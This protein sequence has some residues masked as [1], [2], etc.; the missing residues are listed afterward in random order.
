MY[1]ISAFSYAGG[2]RLR[3]GLEGFL[4]GVA[5]AKLQASDCIT[6]FSKIRQ[7]LYFHPSL[8]P[9]IISEPM[10]TPSDRFELL[11]RQYESLIEIFDESTKLEARRR[12]LRQMNAVLLEIDMLNMS[13]LKF[14]K[15]DI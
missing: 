4:T 2:N 5:T 1:L 6:R 8:A 11:V 15:Q 9:A 10:T 3:G 12:L 7:I 14:D 13:S